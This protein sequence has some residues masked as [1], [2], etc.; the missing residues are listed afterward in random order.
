M[1]G[2]RGAQDVCSSGSL[3]LRLR[4]GVAQSLWCSRFVFLGICVAE[5]LGWCESVLLMSHLARNMCGAQS[6]SLRLKV[7]VAEDLCC[8]MCVLLLMY[9]RQDPCCSGCVVPR[10]MICVV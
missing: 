10:L 7:C 9:A 2:I 4:I 1:H 3:F 5:E 8:S 6:V